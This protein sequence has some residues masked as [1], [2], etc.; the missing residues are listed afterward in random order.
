M[1][2]EKWRMCI[3]WWFALLHACVFCMSLASSKRPIRF[4]SGWLCILLH[5][6]KCPP[7][8]F[9]R[10]LSC[11]SCSGR[12]TL[13]SLRVRK[14]SLPARKCYVQPL[15]HMQ[16]NGP[17]ELRRVELVHKAHFPDGFFQNTIL[18]SAYVSVSMGGSF[19]DAV[20]RIARQCD[21]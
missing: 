11:S 4:P 8:L 9:S 21:N 6:T 20:H 5:A 18:L 19:L 7:M 15:Y 2:S 13:G 10:G 16:P 14:G 3:L 17:L 12:H 1:R